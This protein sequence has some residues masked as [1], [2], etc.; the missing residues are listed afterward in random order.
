MS[1]RH[2]NT[3]IVGAGQAGLAMSAHLSQQGIDHLVL[4]RDRIAERWRTARW[5]SLVANGPAW[6]DRFPM[7]EFEDCEADGFP[8]RDSVVRYFETVAERIDAPVRCGVE[9]TAASRRASGDGFNVETSEGSL[10]ADNIVVA[11]GPFQTP[12]IPPVVPD[13]VI[14]QIHSC[15]YRNPEQ[16]EDGGVLIVGA[17]SSGSQIA[18]ELLRS[19][20]RTWLSIGPHDRPPRSYRGKD[21]VWWLGV[22]GKWQM[23]TPPAGREHVTIAVSGAYGGKTVD[24]R[25]FAERGMTLL[26]MTRHYEN[27]YLNIADDLARNIAEGDA[28][29][30]GLLA[31]ADA[32]VTA[33]GLDLPPEEEAKIIPPDP[34]CVKSPVRRLDLT[35]SGIANIIWAT[36]YRQTFDW[37]RVDVFDGNGKPAHHRGVGTADGVYFLGLPWLSMRGSSFI[38]GVWEDAAYL[39][40]HIAR[41]RS[42]DRA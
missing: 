8:T 5:D 10:S 16:L 40:S 33:K 6:H 18:D 4:E 3:L 31:E 12:I 23:K 13:G 38:W 15:N 11:T 28:N 22:L 24:F 19:G 34:D 17:G 20:R 35:E 7:L 14:N 2:V 27:G 29:H 9:V 30:L 32:Y 1:D 36:G 39:A 26:G 25:R 41:G 37:L 42:S 21:F